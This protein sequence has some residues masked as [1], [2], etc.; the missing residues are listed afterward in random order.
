MD[1]FSRDLLTACGPF[2][3]QVFAWCILPNH[4]HMLVATSDV[5]ALLAELGRLHG[6]T[7]YY[8]NGEENARGRQVFFRA[9][10]R[11]MRS[12]RHYWA[13]LNYVHHNAVHHGYVARWQDWPWSSAAQY[14]EEMGAEEALR[15]WKEFPILE[16]GEGWD[17]AEF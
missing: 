5:L 13:T 7:S 9:A 1:D 12:E 8:W 14:L 15:V 11:V 4:Y 2:V 3:D 6:R 17:D 16:Y 10:E